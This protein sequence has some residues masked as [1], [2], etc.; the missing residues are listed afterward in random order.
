M[1]DMIACDATNKKYKNKLTKMT[2]ETEMQM[3]KK[4]IP[5]ARICPS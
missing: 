2:E 4:A 5:Q 3:L 1:K